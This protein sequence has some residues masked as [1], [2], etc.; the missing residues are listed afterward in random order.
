MSASRRSPWYYPWAPLGIGALTFAAVVAL[1][2]AGPPAQQAQAAPRSRRRPPSGIRPP[3]NLSSP[4]TCPAPKNPD[5]PTRSASNW[6]T[7]TARC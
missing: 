6:W 5:P 3:T 7:P 4:S 2:L 1:L